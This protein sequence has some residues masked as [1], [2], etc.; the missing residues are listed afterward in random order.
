MKEISIG[1]GLVLMLTI[2]CAQAQDKID[3][4][5]IAEY[6]TNL[7][8]QELA[9][10]EDQQ[11][12]VEPINL[13]YAEKAAALLNAEGSMF[14]KIGD[15]QENNQQKKDT[16]STVLTEAQLKKYEDELEPTF[17]QYFRNKMRQ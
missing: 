15:I 17:R 10:N 7:M 3:A 14:S 2:H 1:L 4:Q 8:V 9:L 16:L 5:E 12:E 11:N 6:Q 13:R